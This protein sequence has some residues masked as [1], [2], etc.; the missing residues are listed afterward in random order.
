MKTK[1]DKVTLKSS[2]TVSFFI[3]VF[4]LLFSTLGI[5][6]IWSWLLPKVCVFV[7][8]LET[9][10][11]FLDD[12]GRTNINNIVYL[13]SACLAMLPSAILAYR[14][15]K[16]RKKE[17][18][19]HSKARISYTGGLKYHI[20]EYGFSDAVCM[21]AI[22]GVLTLCYIFAGNTWIIRNIPMIFYPLSTLGIILGVLLVVVLTGISM[23]G[24]I[25]FA[26]RRWRAEHFFEE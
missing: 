26:Q 18:I 12:A 14:I 8:E 13:V 23:L 2:L 17:F 7:P 1:I 20:Q 15:S 22:I 24:G 5:V 25:F 6:F 3:L 4:N 11:E 9:Y 19:K 10:L 16:K 21:L